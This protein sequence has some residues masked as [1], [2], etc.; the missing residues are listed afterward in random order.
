[1]LFDIMLMD[2]VHFAVHESVHEVLTQFTAH[3][4][5]VTGAICMFWR[6]RFGW[7]QGATTHGVPKGTSR[8]SNA[9][10][11]RRWAE[12][13]SMARGLTVAFGLRLRRSSL[14]DLKVRGAPRLLGS[15]QN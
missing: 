1:M 10:A 9:A 2:E 12:V 11:S 5:P 14:A 8:R 6:P 13:F 3:V 4:S 7:M 15:P